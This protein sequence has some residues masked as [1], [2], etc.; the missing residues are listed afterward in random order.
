MM[1][2]FL[3]KNTTLPYTVDLHSHLLPGLD[4]GVK[5]WEES[6][7]LIRQLNKIGIKKVITTPHIIS[8]Y[9]P[10]SPDKITEM[11]DILNQKLTQEN[12][13]VVVEAGAEYY[14][15]DW[16]LGMAQGDQKLLSFGDNYILL[17]TAF[18][19]KPAFLSDTF[20]ALKSRGLQPILAHPERYT[21]LQQDHETL[22]L[23]KETGIKLQVNASSFTG[24]YSREAKVTAEYMVQEKLVDFVGSDIHRQAHFDLLVKASKKR[25]F[26]QVRQ[27]QLLNS[28]L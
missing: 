14:I 18:M 4:D 19:N 12:V 25:I 21:Y 16:F 5:T 1:F 27:L 15:D 9:Y 3:K 2:D 13:E 23:L 6:L 20:F 8:D 7:S 17:E 24:H 26:K 28:T 10:N 11:V 22:H